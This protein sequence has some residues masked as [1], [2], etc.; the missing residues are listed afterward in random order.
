[1]HN[2]PCHTSAYKFEV[3]ARY[4]QLGNWQIAAGNTDLWQQLTDDFCAFC[5][6][7][8]LFKKYG[9]CF[10]NPCAQTGCQTACRFKVKVFNCGCGGGR[11]GSSKGVGSGSVNY[12][13][14]SLRFFPNEPPPKNDVS[15]EVSSHF[16]HVS[17]KVTRATQFAGCHWWTTLTM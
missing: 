12:C 16:H 13:L 11:A 9:I 17:R 3:Y 15:G 14:L 2:S 6:A 10:T 8:R 7:R 5:H 4:R 1:M